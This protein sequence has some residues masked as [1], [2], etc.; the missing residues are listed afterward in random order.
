[1]FYAIDK[2]GYFKKMLIWDLSTIGY[3]YDYGKIIRT[4]YLFTSL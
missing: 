2:R 3:S 4:A 1:M